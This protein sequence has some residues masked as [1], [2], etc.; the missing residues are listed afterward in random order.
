MLKIRALI[1][2]QRISL[3]KT[4]LINFKCLPFRQAIH[5]PIWIYGNTYINSLGSIRIDTDEEIRAGMIRIGSGN[6]FKG[7]P[8]YWSNAGTVTFKGY[9]MIEGGTQIQ[10]CGNITFDKDA[11]LCECVKVLIV[12]ELYIGQSTQIAFESVIMDTDFHYLINIHDGVVKQ[13]IK[14]IHIGSFNWSGNRTVFR[15]GTVTP[16]HT[17]IATN[18][19]LSKDY[20]DEGENILLAG[21]PAKCV[22]KGIR[23]FWRTDTSKLCFQFFKDNP[24]VNSYTVNGVEDWDDFTLGTDKHHGDNFLPHHH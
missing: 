1:A 9:A 21:Q 5:L 3:F 13:S 12:D 19:I 10:S 4:I 14:P 24:A 16:D 18:S 15:K 22:K 17:V 2:R 7:F 23:R 6:F 8:T 11:R 20:T